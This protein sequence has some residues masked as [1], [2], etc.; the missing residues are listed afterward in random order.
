ME[1]EW[2]NRCDWDLELDTGLEL[3]PEW[4]SGTSAGPVVDVGSSSSTTEIC[5]LPLAD[6]SG[7]MRGFTDFASSRGTGKGSRL[8]ASWRR[9]EPEVMACRRA[10]S[11]SPASLL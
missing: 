3:D 8:R 1:L 6:E 4:N 10:Q 7:S 9:E 11:F 5:D 2:D